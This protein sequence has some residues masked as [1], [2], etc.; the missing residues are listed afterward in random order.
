MGAWSWPDKDLSK[1]PIFRPAG[2][3]IKTINPVVSKDISQGVSRKTAMINC[4]FKG[5]N[6]NMEGDTC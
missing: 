4:E 1:V 6:L 5:L 3:N 2:F